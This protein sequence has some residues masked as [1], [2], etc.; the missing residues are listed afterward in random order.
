MR[1]SYDRRSIS[2]LPYNSVKIQITKLKDKYNLVR[3][4]GNDKRFFNHLHHFVLTA[5]LYNDIG[6]SFKAFIYLLLVTL[7]K[8]LL[9][10]ALV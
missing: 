5:E 9:A 2:R 8:K 1:K 4:S 3:Q 7:G 6:N 10:T